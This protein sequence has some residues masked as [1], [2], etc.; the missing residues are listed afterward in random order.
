MMRVT[1][2]VALTATLLASGCLQGLGFTDD[3]EWAYD[4]ANLRDVAATGRGVRVAILDTGIDPS[5]PSLQHLI[6]G[7]TTN[8][9]LAGFVDFLTDI[10]GPE[11]AFDDN[12]HGTHVASII[13]SRPM[14]DTQMVRYGAVRLD[15]AANDVTLYVARVCGQEECDGR[16]I[17]DAI[18]WAIRERVQVMSLSLGGADALLDLSDDALRAAVQ[19]AIDRG[20]VVVAAAGNGGPGA[21]EDE[22]RSDVSVPADVP[23]VIAVAAVDQ[24]LAPAGFSSR[25]SNG[26]CRTIPLVGSP[27]GRCDPNR[28]PEISAPGVDILGAWID[29]GFARASGTSQATPFVSAAVALMLE[30]RAPLQNADGVARVKSILIETA[31]SLPDAQG[32]HS[33]ATG[34][35]LLDAAAAAAAYQ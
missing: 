23:G 32:N 18:D 27:T 12:G 13:T 25:G 4:A 21:P 9:E 33:D 5:H 16:A 1:T 15:G 29:R 8:G 30:G 22:R 2:L 11:N 17:L 26:E 20:I 3:S 6:D 35:G 28:K 14:S 19:R 24:Q 34:Y 31:A 10:R 7:D